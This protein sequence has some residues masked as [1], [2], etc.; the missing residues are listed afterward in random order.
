MNNHKYYL[1]GPL[2]LVVYARLGSSFIFGSLTC[3]YT[4]VD[5]QTVVRRLTHTYGTDG[6]DLIKDDGYWSSLMTCDESVS[7]RAQRGSK[8]V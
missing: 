6:M 4:L 3:L 1:A 2:H 8:S 5:H 7:V